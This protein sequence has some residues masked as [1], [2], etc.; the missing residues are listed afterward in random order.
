MSNDETHD[1][2]GIM[3]ELA[4]NAELIGPLLAKE[5]EPLRSKLPGELKDLPCLRL[6]ET[7]GLCKDALDRL[8]PRIA[9]R[10]A[11]EEDG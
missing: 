2:V 5:L 7:P 4:G 10:L 11:A 8:R 6:M 3:Q 1:L 9:A